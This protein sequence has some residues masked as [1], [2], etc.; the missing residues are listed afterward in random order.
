M[1]PL[2]FCRTSSSPNTEPHCDLLST[3]QSGQGFPGY[4]AL[5][6]PYLGS[7]PEWSSL[8]DQNLFARG[9]ETI[10]KGAAACA[11]TDDN[12]VVMGSIH[13]GNGAIAYLSRLAANGGDAV[14]ERT[15]RLLKFRR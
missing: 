7:T 6:C 8:Q 11:S 1:L 15:R 2:H 3:T 10:G 4:V 14:I 9:R 5:F 13:M 12:Q